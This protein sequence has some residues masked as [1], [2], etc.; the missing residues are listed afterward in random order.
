MRLL[1]ATTRQLSE[2]PGDNIPPYAI[3][4]HRW[5]GAEVS[6]QD[7]RDG[8]GAEMQG[9]G[10]IVECCKQA[11]SDGFEYAVSEF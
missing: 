7:L 6:F 11:L 9:Y 4:S 8:R 1:N 10:K 3:L 2:F 5:E